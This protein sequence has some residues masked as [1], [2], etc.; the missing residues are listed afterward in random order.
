[1]DMSVTD[2]QIPFQSGQLFARRW[3]VTDLTT[4]PIVLMHDSLGCV[5]LWRDFPEQLALATGRNVVAY[6]R[7]GFGRSSACQEPLRTDFVRTEASEAFHAVCQFFE[8]EK[9]IVMGHS[10]G[11]GMSVCCAAQYP[12]RCMALV[13]MSAQAFVE[14]RTRKGIILANEA[15][16]DQQQF[17]RL[18]KYHGGQAQWVLSAWVDTW[19]S[20]PFAEWT[21]DTE[22]Q[23]VQ[24]P[25]LVIHGEHDEYGSL[26]HPQRYAELIPV[27]TEVR[28]VE[29]A[30]HM[31]HKEK[32]AEVL[33]YIQQFLNGIA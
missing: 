3:Q 8:I 25:A 6:D 20:E 16:Q 26:L 27:Q 17:S 28:I 1:M 7:Y 31:P 18:E 24:C 21:I 19:L 33:Q 12:D 5:A 32:T 30:F 14:D 2:F 4:V 15:F 22:L 11:G 9:F 29:G 13:T 23:Q 10:V